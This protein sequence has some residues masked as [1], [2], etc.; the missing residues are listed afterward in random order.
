M[1]ILDDLRRA[2]RACDD[3]LFDQCEARLREILDC[4]E[5]AA[6]TAVGNTDGLSVQDQLTAL[7]SSVVAMAD[8][9]DRGECE[10]C[11]GSGRVLDHNKWY[12]DDGKWKRSFDE[13]ISIDCPECDGAKVS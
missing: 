8:A 11:E 9:M 2:Y 4:A 5:S 6:V 13:D 3:P 10:T 7:R 12:V 1:Q